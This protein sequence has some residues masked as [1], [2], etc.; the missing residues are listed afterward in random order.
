MI[1]RELTLE[2]Q[3]AFEK[4]LDQWDG[5]EG[6]SMLYGL[7]EGM[8]FQTYLNL[9]NEMRDGV[10]LVGD[11][12]AATNLFAFEGPEIVGKVSVRHTLNKHLETVGGHIGYGVLPE[13]RQK[14]YASLMLKEALKYGRTLGLTRVLLTCDEGNL[15]SAKIIIK[16]GG[17]FE[18]LFD[19]KNGSSK[20][21]RFWIEL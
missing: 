3:S 15:P 9:M 10:N 20:K 11:T 13:F 2:D 18:N 17:V 7:L 14:G 12:V 5:A 8:N 16:N 21:K 19:P 4:M 1:L 6:F